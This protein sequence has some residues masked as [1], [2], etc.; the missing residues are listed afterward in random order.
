[1]TTATTRTT[2][3]KWRRGTPASPAL[4]RPDFPCTLKLPDG[5]MLY[6]E[7]PGRWVT[8]DRSGEPAFLPPAVKFLDQVQAL[9]MSAVSRPP[10]PGYVTTLRE[11]LGLT[12][13]ELGARIGVHKLTVS[14][15]ERGTLRPSAD[16]LE[17]IDKLRREAVRRGVTIAS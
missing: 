4:S 17:K 1:M 10:S 16:A 5:R 11:A 6:V 2:K 14:R 12:Q 7:V 3:R 8:T 15:W 9:A 13:K